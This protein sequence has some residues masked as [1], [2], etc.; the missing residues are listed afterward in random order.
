MKYRQHIVSQD[1]QCVCQLHLQNLC[2]PVMTDVVTWVKYSPEKTV[3]TLQQ[4][5]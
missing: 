2:S 3:L 5:R 4:A 1:L